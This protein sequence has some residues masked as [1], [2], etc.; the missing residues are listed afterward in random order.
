VIAVLAA[1]AGVLAPWPAHSE[2][3]TYELTQV[4]KTTRGTRRMAFGPGHWTASAAIQYY[5]AYRGFYIFGRIHFGL[6]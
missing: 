4:L 2:G 5:D 6:H 3:V 1:L